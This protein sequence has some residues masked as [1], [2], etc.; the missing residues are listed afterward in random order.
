MLENVDLCDFGREILCRKQSKITS[1]GAISGKGQ[2][3]Y[4]ALTVQPEQQLEEELEEDFELE[5]GGLSL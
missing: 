2:E 3:L 5:M 1:Y 4:S